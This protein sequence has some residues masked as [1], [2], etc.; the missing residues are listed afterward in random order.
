MRI[1][2]TT[3]GRPH[4]FTHHASVLA[5]GRL[6]S[7]RTFGSHPWRTFADLTNG[8]VSSASGRGARSCRALGGP[9]PTGGLMN[10]LTTHYATTRWSS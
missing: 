2:G 3:V 5:G 9:S 7:G 8:E 1:E 6:C 10:T 4:L